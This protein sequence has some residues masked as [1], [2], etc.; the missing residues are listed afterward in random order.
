MP[1]NR[2][3]VVTSRQAATK[4]VTVFV[5]RNAVVIAFLLGQVA[6]IVLTIVAG[7]A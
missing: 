6:G 1:V 3:R 2:P 4:T 5:S 7:L